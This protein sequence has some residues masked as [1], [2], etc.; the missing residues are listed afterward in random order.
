[1]LIVEKIDNNYFSVSS[2]YSESYNKRFK[3]IDGQ[4]F[5]SFSKK[6]IVPMN[7]FYLFEFLFLGEI[8]F[9]TPRWEFTG[10]PIPDYSKQ[11]ILNDKDLVL[12]KLKLNP[13]SYQEYGARYMI[14]KINKYGFVIN[15]DAVGLGKTIQA[16][17][18]FSYY[19]QNNKAKN[20]LLLCKKALKFQWRNEI[21]KFTD[22]NIDQ[23]VILDGATNKKVKQAIKF[24]ELTGEK[25]LITNY[26][27]TQAKC[28]EHLKDI[29]FDILIVDEA[30]LISNK[31]VKNK[32]ITK[33]AK[34]IPYKLFLTGTP[35][36]NR[37]DNLYDLVK[38]ANNK[39]FGK[40]TDFKAKYLRY[41]T[42]KYGPNIVGYLNLDE[43]EEKAQNILIRR[44][45]NEV[46][47]DL[48]KMMPP[49]KVLCDLDDTQI[50]LFEALE[51]EKSKLSAA[52]SKIE[53]K[54]DL[55][56]DDLNKIE[57]LENASKGFISS[58]QAIANDPRLFTMSKSEKIR[59]KFG[60]L[61]PKS[62]KGS[63]KTQSL[64]DIVGDIV[65]AGEKVIIFTKFETS[66]QL[67]KSDIEKAFKEYDNYQCVLFTGAINSEDRETNVKLFRESDTHNIFIATSAANEGVNLQ[68]AN[69]VIHYD[70]A[71]TSAIR[72][73]RN[74][75]ARR[76]GSKLSK[77]YVYDLLSVDT[78][79][80]SKYEE[81]KRQEALSFSISGVNSA[82]SKAIKD[83]M[84]N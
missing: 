33:L 25:I 28:F 21:E 65:D 58:S 1:M 72:V 8:I 4:Y 22:F 78:V 64:I 7:S 69:H 31:G 16:I 43:L 9:K 60:G 10:E 2:K 84:Y 61:I 37:A 20:I 5:D 67:I 81:I 62:Y 79:D 44:T 76:V 27:V 45:E 46:D 54:G 35:I 11:Y 82:R 49:R 80:T 34:K 36:M 24:K 63:I 83:A 15:S 74:G 51:E 47:I 18:T 56:V 6:R 12:P 30:H 55:T 14:E 40:W 59:K 39:Y 32:E 68:C 53:C 48:P 70:V 75:R 42:G 19:T 50:K 26:E 23:V 66:T 13:Y 73:Q 38:I 71:D 29:K 52:I 17:Q 41:E 3:E 77:V 57:K